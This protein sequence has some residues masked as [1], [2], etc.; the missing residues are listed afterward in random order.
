MPAA[1]ATSSAPRPSAA[2][3]AFIAYEDLADSKAQVRC[4]TQVITALAETASLDQDRYEAA[5][6]RATHCAIKLLRKADQVR[7]VVLCSRLFWRGPLAGAA[8][9]ARP[10]ELLQC[11]QKALSI[12][13][14]TLPAQPGLFVDIFDAYVYYYEKR[15]PAVQAAHVR[16][17]VSLT[18]EQVETMKP[19]PER[20]EAAAH[21]KGII[22][23]IR[24]AQARPDGAAL[25]ADVAV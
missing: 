11:L 2:H 15:V 6:S 7:C 12:A 20:D 25:Y 9:Y 4:L 10:K 22:A 16:D 17:L 23:H 19:S 13:D 21:L 18:R 8:A 14:K 3:A 1:A 5:A 24:R